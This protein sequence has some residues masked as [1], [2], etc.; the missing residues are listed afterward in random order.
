M[1]APSIPSNVDPARIKY[2]Q[3]RSVKSPPGVEPDME[4]FYSDTGEVIS[5]PDNET[6]TP[7]DET[8]K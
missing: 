7:R 1:G 3:M 5:D 6:P 4:L 2:V 8:K